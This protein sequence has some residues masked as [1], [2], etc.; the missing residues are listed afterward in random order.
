MNYYLWAWN[1]F[2][3]VLFAGIV[4]SVLYYCYKE[5][6]TDY[7]KEQQLL[8][9]QEIVLSKIRFAQEMNE[10]RK[11]SGITDLPLL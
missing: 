1:I 5:K 6:P 9:D 11:T 2:V 7:E 10:K 4:G 3:F 8:R